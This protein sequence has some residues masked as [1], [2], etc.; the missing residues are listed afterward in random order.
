MR[1]GVK[2]CG[3]RRPDLPLRGLLLQVRWRRF[4]V[5]RVARL[6]QS[7]VHTRALPDVITT[8]DL[9]APL[10]S[11]AQTF[12]L[13]QNGVGI[14]RDL[15]RAVPAA[16]IISANAWV[17]ATTL[18]GGKRV[19]QTGDVSA[20]LCFAVACPPML[21]PLKRLLSGTAHHRRP[22]HGSD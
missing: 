20:L 13:I 17:D 14:E 18:D 3:R 2:L 21:T 15:Q 10:L 4:R 6:T 9:I 5:P 11:R 12:V 1:S 16:T 19:E 22:S 7:S 8:P